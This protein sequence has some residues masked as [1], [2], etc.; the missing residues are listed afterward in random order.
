MVDSDGDG[1]SDYDEIN[2]YKTNPREITS[3]ERI[4]Q[5]RLSNVSQ[6][7]NVF[8]DD[9]PVFTGT[10]KPNY[11]VKLL[12]IPEEAPQLTF[13]DH[14][15]ASLFGVEKNGAI[16]LEV[17]TDD[18]GKFLARPKLKDG[19]YIII[20][21]SLDDEGNM[22]DETVPYSFEVDSGLDADLVVPQQLG[23]TPIDLESL[24]AFTIGDSRPYL[25]GK[26]N[27]KNLEVTTNWSS[28]L[29][30][31]SFLVDTDEGDFLTLAPQLLEDGSHELNVY[32][33]DLEHNLY[34]SAINID[35]HVLSSTL[36]QA[37]NDSKK[38]WQLAFFSL[39]GLI[40]LGGFWIMVRRRQITTS[41]GH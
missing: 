30:S 41:R 31:S 6:N 40:G 18:N 20:V 10:S 24:Q 22:D 33:K 9:T 23:E 32:A 3:T 14:L 7:L 19:N 27:A 12:I 15:F 5:P 2:V 36:Y 38:N 16:T 8:A 25:Y 26:V 11:S 17:E 1:V 29:Y 28:Q 13:V 35:F 39:I 4:Q 37:A 21:R 34:S